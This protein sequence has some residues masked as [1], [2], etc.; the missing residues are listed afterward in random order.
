MMIKSDII[1]KG[2]AMRNIIGIAIC[3]FFMSF[4]H[5]CFADDSNDVLK[6]LD[7]Q[8]NS[9]RI[10]ENMPVI[11]I[12]DEQIKQV[13]PFK[14]LAFLEKYEND[15]SVGVRNIVF[16]HEV[17]LTKLNKDNLALRQ[18]IVKRLVKSFFDFPSN[19]LRYESILTFKEIDFNE[20]AKNMIR[21]E[22]VKTNVDSKTILICGAAN[23]KDQLPR[24]E[25]ILIE[26]S[27]NQT[28]SEIK[29]GA[30]WYLTNVGAARFARARM[31][32]KEEI[33]K[34]IELSEA[35]KNSNERVLRILP[36]IGY[37]RQPET[38]KYLIKYLNSND[39]L[40]PTNPGALGEPYAN[41]IVHIFA[42]SLENFPVKVKEARN[43]T[44]EEID[45]CRKWMSQQKEWK[46]IR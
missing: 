40:S 38:I 43:Y 19:A 39:R 30:P 35:E 26:G 23:I 9:R 12:T 31:G 45:L 25:E 28:N 20:D 34:C 46:I 37:I 5:F 29:Y 6:L 4:V 10:K 24:L 27:K 13:D 41:R 42:E 22:L 33:D 21:K 11:K 18:E 8:I 1:S 32:V 3:L 14:I 7:T 44:K 15:Q 36:K 17:N 2:I 16:W